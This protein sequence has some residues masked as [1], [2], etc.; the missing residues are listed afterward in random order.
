M[1][2]IG[3]LSLSFFNLVLGLI[4]IIRS[5]RSKTNLAFAALAIVTAAWMTANYFGANFKDHA[6]APY[7]THGDFFLGPWIMFTFWAFTYQFLSQA[8]SKASRFRNWINKFLLLLAVAF[9]F[10]SL[11]PL[12]ATVFIDHNGLLAITYGPLFS[13]YGI[14]LILGVIFGFINLIVGRAKATGHLKHQINNLLLGLVLFVVFLTVPNLLVPLLTSSKHINLIAGDIAYLGIVAFVVMSFLAIVKHH[15]FDVRLAIV[16][17]VGFVFTLIIIASL[18]SLLAVSASVLF[19]GSS[20][21]IYKDPATV[22]VLFASTFLVA[23]TFRLVQNMTIKLTRHIFRQDEYD[24]REVLDK[25]SE[26]LV[27][28]NEIDKIMQSSLAIISGAI[29]PNSAYFVV[30]TD[31]GRVHRSIPHNG[32]IQ[33]EDIKEIRNE[34]QEFRVN[35]IIVDDIAST[36]VP[37]IIGKNQISLAL[38]LGGMN[39]PRGLILFTQKQNGRPYSKTDIG[40]LRIISKNLKIALENAMK[41]EQISRF[42]DTLKEEVENATAKLRRANSR[43]KSLDVLKNDFMSMASHQLRSPA[44]SVHEALHMLNH[45]ALNE[46]DREDLVALAEANSERLVTVVK[47]MLN[48]ARLQAGRFT[49]D[50]SEENVT[51]LAEKVVDQTNTIADQR[52]IKLKFVKP[53]KPIMALIDAA[54]ITEAMANYVENAIKYS[55]QG[56]TVQAELKEVGDRI[57]FE[58]KDSGMGVPKEERDHLFGKFYRASNARQEEPDGNGIGLYVVH[59]IAHGHGGDTYYKP[60]EKGSLFGFWITHKHLA[61]SQNS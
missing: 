26:Q 3:V 50:R 37:K 11:L 38:W 12:V 58:V 48:M 13:V 24:L 61:G 46:K 20:V 7:A 57:I 4:V 40:L 14:V 32:T 18:Y 34:L 59:S 28:Q 29:R 8:T 53:A 5:S 15:M 9:S 16:R 35:P 23:L 36:K 47:T 27:A 17:T 42:A 51:K 41:Y 10:G 1:L 45:P 6:F 54:K 43:L 19:I 55:P 44:T 30:F 31:E 25:L 39:H 21:N 49:I 56:S 52:E 60:L 2:T 22:A 33:A